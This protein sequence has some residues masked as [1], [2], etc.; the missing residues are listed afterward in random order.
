MSI[1]K[2]INRAVAVLE[3]SKRITFLMANTVMIEG[4]RTHEP[5]SVPG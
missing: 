2:R 1:A 5:F 3:L 4:A